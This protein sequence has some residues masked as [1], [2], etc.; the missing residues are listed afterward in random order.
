MDSYNSFSSIDRLLD[1]GMSIVVAQQMVNMMNHTMA[2]VQI[3]GTGNP[4]GTNKQTSQFYIVVNDAI[5]GPFSDTELSTLAKA[6]TIVSDTLIWRQ[7]MT[8]WMKAKD[9]PEANKALLLNK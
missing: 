6:K 3:P 7:G 1:F 2:N 4:I 5:A 9:V 8:G